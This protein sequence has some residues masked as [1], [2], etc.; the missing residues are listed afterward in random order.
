MDCVRA[1]QAAPAKILALQP[2]TR[3]SK[4]QQADFKQGTNLTNSF[5]QFV[6]RPSSQQVMVYFKGINPPHGPD[7]LPILLEK[8]NV[9]RLMSRVNTLAS[10]EFAGR[11]PGTKGIAKAEHFIT[12]AFK[13][14]E[15]ESLS[16]PKHKSKFFSVRN[17]GTGIPAD[18]R[19]KNIKLQRILFD[20]HNFENK[21]F[22][23]R[24][25]Y[26]HSYK[27]CEL[28]P[29]S[30][31]DKTK[32]KNFQKATGPNALDVIGHDKF[33]V[34]NVIGYIPAN[35]DEYLFL[36]AHYDHLGRDMDSGKVYP[37]A[38][39]N[40][41]GV[42]ALMEIADV[43]ADSKKVNKNVVFVATS[44]H[45]KGYLGA[46]YLADR[47]KTAVEHGEMQADKIKFINMD[48][49]SSQASYA[50]L[51]GVKGDNVFK[52][53]I[54]NLTGR[55]DINV[56]TVE[57]NRGTDAEAFER[58]GF[59]ATT[60]HWGNMD[61]HDVDYCKDIHRTSDSVEKINESALQKATKLALAMVWEMAG[62]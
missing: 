26:Q 37:G 43:L 33:P 39:D 29:A 40:A 20:D 25:V 44:G 56:K 60:I 48:C 46:S 23:Q 50:T 11:F 1:G 2:I 7:I 57:A 31:L 41:T 5:N 19:E 21:E 27:G 54:D 14:L 47:L 32:I 22:V 42:S 61:K 30:D 51:D 18:V 15:K 8:V 12:D 52:K 28:N 17:H 16:K 62:K 34:E 59:D 35:S 4:L 49:L 38:V 3:A 45:E 24:V 6:A 36:T 58:Y 9:K 55:L 13:K 53:A 10:E